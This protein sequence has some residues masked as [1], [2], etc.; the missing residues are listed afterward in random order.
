MS[1]LFGERIEGVAARERSGELEGAVLRVSC[2]VEAP[3]VI[4]GV[5]A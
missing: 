4:Y 5:T 2:E 1:L 3:A